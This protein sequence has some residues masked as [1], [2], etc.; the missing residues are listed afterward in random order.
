MGAIINTQNLYDMGN[1]V[2][3][4]VKKFVSD[5]EDEIACSQDNRSVLN[6]QIT[7]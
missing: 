2:E 4:Y 3:P 1:K 7:N 6:E 5:D